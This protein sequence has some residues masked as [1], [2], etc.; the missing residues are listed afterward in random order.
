MN[1]L[2]TRMKPMAKNV[3]YGKYH[4]YK[5]E[6]LV[7]YT[8]E[9]AQML[10]KNYDGFY[11]IPRSGSFVANMLAMMKGKEIITEQMV[12][13][14]NVD[15]KKKYLLVDDSISTGKTMNKVKDFLDEYGIDYDTAAVFAKPDMIRKVDYYSRM[16]GNHRIFE[17]N[18]MH[19]KWYK[20]ACDM[21]GVLC[22]DPVKV[23][24]ESYRNLE[25]LYLPFYTIDYIITNRLEKYR[26]VTEEWLDKHNVEYGK[27]IMWDVDKPLKGKY[28]RHKLDM[29]FWVSPDVV[30]ESRD[31]QAKYI[32]FNTGIPTLSI[33][34]MVMYI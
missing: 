10:N 26:D 2:I 21:D 9:L 24:E 32:H 5:F 33:E 29:V 25:P 31:S 20:L 3:K 34:K 16:T 22:K 6:D 27:L 13:Q 28:G 17:W 14:G 4:F 15:K 30:F 12:M 11:G 19:K 23:D 18:I 8:R 1:K 7:I